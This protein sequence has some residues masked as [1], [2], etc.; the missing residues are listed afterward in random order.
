M[1]HTCK[2][3]DKDRNL[4]RRSMPQGREKIQ[5]IHDLDIIEPYGYG[6]HCDSWSR[7]APLFSKRLESSKD[8]VGAE[9][10]VELQYKY[11][12]ALTIRNGTL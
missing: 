7:S 8:N 2:W 4:L 10:F 6:M 1:Y 11:I 5:E 12:D 3:Q 9:E